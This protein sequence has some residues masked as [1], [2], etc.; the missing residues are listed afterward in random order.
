MSNARERRRAAEN[1]AACLLI[2]VLASALM[3]PL[4]RL[5]TFPEEGDALHFLRR[6]LL[7]SLERPLGGGQT[8]SN[9]KLMCK[10]GSVNQLSKSVHD[11]RSFDS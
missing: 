11:D 8:E 9:Y 6:L 7:T 3:R 4:L 2:Y 1:V 5:K 10:Q